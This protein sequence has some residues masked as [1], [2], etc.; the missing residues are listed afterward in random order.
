MDSRIKSSSA[1]SNP[2]ALTEGSILRALLALSVPIVLANILQSAY[3][4]T[5]RFWVGQLNSAAV[6]AVTLS[7][8]IN[9]LLIAVGGGLPIA[10]SVLMAQYKGRGDEAAMNHVS[11]QTL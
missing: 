4:M 3:S 5:D 7:F 9:F 11:A 8:P 10:G 6:A 1:K 2:A